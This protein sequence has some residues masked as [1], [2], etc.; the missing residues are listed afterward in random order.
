MAVTE[1]RS[2]SQA[3]GPFQSKQQNIELLA[4]SRCFI[5]FADPRL[6][7]QGAGRSDNP[8]PGQRI[9]AAVLLVQSS[10][11]RQ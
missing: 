10:E 5:S 2:H 9:S 11:P 3:T 1:C 8:D 6:I 4:R 7:D